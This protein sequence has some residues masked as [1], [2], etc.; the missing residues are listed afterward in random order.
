M[1]RRDFASRWAALSSRPEATFLA[2]LLGPDHS[3]PVWPGSWSG[4][5]VCRGGVLEALGGGAG[6]ASWGIRWRSLVNSV[7]N[8]RECDRWLPPPCGDVQD[9]EWIHSQDALLF[10]RC[11][12]LSEMDVQMVGEGRLKKKTCTHRSWG[13]YRLCS[14]STA[15]MRSKAIQWW[16]SFLSSDFY[17]SS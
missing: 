4:L 2:G 11:C 16:Q 8:L 13:V 5:W 17:C 10:P 15:E 12:R 9:D 7:C 14:G 3:G 1:L 6:W